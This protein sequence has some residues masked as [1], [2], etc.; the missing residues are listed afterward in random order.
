MKMTFVRDTKKA[1][2][3]F[4]LVATDVAKDGGG[5]WRWMYSM[6][7][8]EHGWQGKRPAQRPLGAM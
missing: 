8:C 6:G 1:V 5:G 4:N 7:A 3:Q 2:R